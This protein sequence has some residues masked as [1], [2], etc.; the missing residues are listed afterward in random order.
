MVVRC[1]PRRWCRHPDSNWGPTAYKAVALPTE[2]CRRWRG[3]LARPRTRGVRRGNGVRAAGQP[4]APTD[5]CG[6]CAQ[7]IPSSAHFRAGERSNEQDLQHRL[8]DIDVG[9]GC[10]ERT[11]LRGDAGATRGARA[12]RRALL[13]A[14]IGGI[15]GVAP[16]L[17]AQSLYWDGKHTAPTR[18]AARGPGTT[19][20]PTGIPPR[21]PA[22]RGFAAMRCLTPGCSAA[23]AR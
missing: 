5:N 18:T 12:A 14:T 8:V 10:R 15:L 21:P 19:P 13:A 6:G 3:I 2:L 11:R 23:A 16:P 9:L 22:E 20:W 1:G 4:R 17:R 7:R